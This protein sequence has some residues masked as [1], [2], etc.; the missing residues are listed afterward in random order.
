MS[1]NEK[2]KTWWAVG[3]WT[4]KQGEAER[5]FMVYGILPTRQKAIELL[6][7]GEVVRPVAPRYID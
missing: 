5:Q 1:K 2:P 3:I 6:N 7:P 4:R